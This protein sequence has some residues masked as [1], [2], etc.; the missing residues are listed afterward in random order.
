MTAEGTVGAPTC[1]YLH[2][3]Q[4]V[5]YGCGVVVIFRCSI[6]HPESSLLDCLK[7][8][9]LEIQ[10]GVAKSNQCFAKTHLGWMGYSEPAVSYLI[11]NLLP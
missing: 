2:H 10:T 7:R 1:F 8:L 11:V 5:A 6:I 3:Y 9:L 4:V